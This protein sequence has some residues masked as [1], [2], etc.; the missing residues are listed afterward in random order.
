MFIATVYGRAPRD[1][2]LRQAKSG[3]DWCRLTLAVDAGSDRETGESHTLW[4]T[5][6]AFG[7]NAEELARVIKG[8]TVAAMGRIEQNIWTTREGTERQ[9][10]NLIA[11]SILTGRS[12]R[13]RGKRQDSPRQ[14]DERGRQAGFDQDLNDP[15]PF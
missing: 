12:G 15:V 5:V 7:R 2:E 6:L 3:K 1:G 14:E 8:E 13:V 10:L 4:V 9:D 11:D